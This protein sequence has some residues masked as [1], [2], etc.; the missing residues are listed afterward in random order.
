[1]LKDIKIKSFKGEYSVI[2]QSDWLKDTSL[3]SLSGAHHIIDSNVARIYAAQLA[4][5]LKDEK[6]ILIDATEDNKSIERVIP[7]LNSLVNNGAKRNHKLIAIG[8]G[9]IQDITSF[10]STI[11]LRGV[12]WEF[13]PTTLLAQ[14]DSCIGSKS[15]INLGGVKNT[16]GTFNPPNCIHI[17]TDFLDSLTEKEIHSGLGEILKVHAIDSMT[18]FDS[19]A[20][21]FPRL[22]SDRNIL[23]QYIHRALLIKKKY[24]ELDE[25]DRGC[26][27]IFNYGHSFGHAI[28]YSTNYLIP[29]GIAISIGMDMANYIAASRG[30][31]DVSHMHR[32]HPV[33]RANYS[34]FSHIE[35][36]VEELLLALKK[37]KKNQGDS[38]G[39]VL[40]VGEFSA[41]ERVDLLLD[42]QFKNDCHNFLNG[43]HSELY[44]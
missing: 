6:T 28:E 27:Q 44:L 20:V 33:L 24:I 8:G 17:C 30:L 39:L 2:F 16:L 38:L 10:I 43:M 37:D 14:S 32:M 25:F 36:N 3:N 41:I 21:D 35:I 11:Y 19:L 13:I 40:P 18:S 4:P 12:R 23:R 7:V 34:E 42:D 1:M 5:I 31:I 15:S 29:H 22:K 26:R 9:V